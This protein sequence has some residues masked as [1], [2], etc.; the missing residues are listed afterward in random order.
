M[1]TIENLHY[2]MDDIVFVDDTV[3][4]CVLSA[5]S[6][7]SGIGLLVETLVD[8]RLVRTKAWRCRRKESISMLDLARHSLVHAACWAFEDNGDILVLE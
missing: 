4:V 2:A 7:S 3:L 8:V 5:V 1:V 6:T